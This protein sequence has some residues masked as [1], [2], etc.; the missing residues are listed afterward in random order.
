MK[1]NELAIVSRQQTTHNVPLQRKFALATN[2]SVVRN[3]M[4]SILEAKLCPALPH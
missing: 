4:H 1:M 2:N 3:Q